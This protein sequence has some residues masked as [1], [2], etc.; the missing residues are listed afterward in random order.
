MVATVV[1]KA[2]WKL[3]YERASEKTTKIKGA[4]KPIIKREKQRKRRSYKRRAE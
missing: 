2:S 3:S 4:K 1:N